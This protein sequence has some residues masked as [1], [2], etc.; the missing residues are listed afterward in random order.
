MQSSLR[1]K[2]GRLG[3]MLAALVIAMTMTPLLGA[4]PPALAQDPNLATLIVNKG[5]D[6]DAPQTVAPLAGATFG[7]FAG[8]AGTR[9]APGAIP[10]YTCITGADG[11]CFV[12]ATPRSGGAQG[13]WIIEQSAPTGWDIVGDLNVGGDDLTE[14]DYNGVFTGGVFAGVVVPVPPAH[15]G[16]SNPTARGP[17]WA[18]ARDNPDLPESCGLNI[19]LLIDVSGSIEPFLDTVKDAANT[20]VDALTGTPSQIALFSFSEHRQPDPHLYPRLDPRRRRD[21]HRR[22][23]RADR[24]QAPRTGTTASG[25]SRPP[26]PTSTRW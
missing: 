21:R 18:D 26:S 5:G 17:V 23:R 8:T 9:P 10:T 12:D 20:F 1:K 3:G 7:F 24:R 25:R 16:Q 6:R 13:Y 14:R 19:A 15:H 4:A 22:R 2:T 11:S